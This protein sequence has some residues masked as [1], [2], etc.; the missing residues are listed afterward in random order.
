[1]APYRAILR[2]YRCDTPYRAIPFQGGQHSPKWSTH[3]GLSLPQCFWLRRTKLRPWSKQNSDQNSDHAKLCIYLGKEKLRP[4]SKF[5]GRENSDHG[6]NNGLPRGGGRSCLDKMVRYPPPWH[7][8]SSHRRIR[9]IPPILQHHWSDSKETKIGDQDDRTT[10]S[11]V[12]TR[13]VQ[14]FVSRLYFGHFLPRLLRT[15]V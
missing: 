2:Y 12:G 1:M 6:L 9:A 13:W 11:V 14:H 4:W 5:L 15:W 10:R 8:A 7:W 3:M